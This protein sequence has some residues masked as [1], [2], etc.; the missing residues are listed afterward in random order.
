MPMT[1]FHWEVSASRCRNWRWTLWR[2]CV[3]KSWDWETELS[4]SIHTND[5]YVYWYT[6]MH[7]YHTSESIYGIYGCFRKYGYP[8]MDGLWW[9]TL[10]TGWFGGTI[11]TIIFGNTHV[12]K[13][14]HLHSATTVPTPPDPRHTAQPAYDLEP[15]F[16]PLAT[17]GFLRARSFPGCRAFFFPRESNKMSYEKWYEKWINF[18]CPIQKFTVWWFDNS[19]WNV[20]S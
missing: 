11:G 17:G 16:S 18:R 12:E 13:S 4:L 7:A 9:K 2:D 8:K 3:Q 20:F 10:L 19:I 1:L 5:V 6:Y 14:L 15:I